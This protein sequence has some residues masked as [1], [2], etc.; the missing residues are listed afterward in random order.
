[1]RPVWI[2]E[3]GHLSRVFSGVALEVNATCIREELDQ[4]VGA[5]RLARMADGVR[6]PTPSVLE[7]FL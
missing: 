2:F 1:M 3:A 7:F 4:A 5:Q 6:K